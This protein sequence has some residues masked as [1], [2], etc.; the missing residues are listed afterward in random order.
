M[1]LLQGGVADADTTMIIDD[2]SSSV[3]LFS[4]LVDGGI[5]MIPIGIL[6]ILAIYVI[7]E[8][9]RFLN[10]SQMDNDKFLSSVEDMLREGNTR[11]AILY[12][13]QMDKPLSRILKQ[14]INRLGRPLVDIEDAIK[15]AGK[16]ETYRLE[17]KMDWL[18]TVAGVAPLLGFLGTVTGMI[19][20]FMQIQSLQGNVNPSVLAGGIWE[21]LI[22]T[23]FGL[24]VGIIAFGFYNYLLNKIN[25]TIFGLEVAST[26]FMEL[27]Q[28]PANKRP[29]VVK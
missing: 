5:L 25:R 13:D 3:N 12:C 26:E 19:D 14:G 10:N 23:A 4:I 20:A 2:A 28:K 17:N 9:W 15:N 7:A 6:W 21:A 18:A 11:Q 24:F 22:T 8:R 29:V 27:L 16:K 1:L